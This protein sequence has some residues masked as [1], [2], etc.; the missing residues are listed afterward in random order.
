MLAD[1]EVL[2]DELGEEAQHILEAAERGVLMNIDPNVTP[3][4]AAGARDPAQ[5]FLPTDGGRPNDCC[6]L[7]IQKRKM[8]DGREV[9]KFWGGSKNPDG[10]VKKKK[11]PVEQAAGKKKVARTKRDATKAAVRQRFLGYRAT[12]EK[13][14]LFDGPRTFE[15]WLLH[16]ASERLESADN[17]DAAPIPQ[18]RTELLC[19][20][21]CVCTEVARVPGGRRER[22]PSDGEESPARKIA[23]TSVEKGCCGCRIEWIVMAENVI[24]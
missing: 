15:A 4:P 17:A 16:V 6:P 18:V 24:K 2:L 14:K 13:R 1:D 7:I 12:Q 22:C 9:S 11:M 20:L 19:L 3:Q 5:V 21:S 8:P 10:S 23:L